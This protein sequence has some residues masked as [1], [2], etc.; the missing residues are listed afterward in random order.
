MHCG[1]RPHAPQPRSHTRAGAWLSLTS[2]GSDLRGLSQG[3][4]RSKRAAPRHALV[5]GGR[6]RQRKGA[7]AVQAGRGG[8]GD[9]VYI[10]VRQT[11]TSRTPEASHHRAV[12]YSARRESPE[13][14]RKFQQ[15][16]QLMQSVE[17]PQCRVCAQTRAGI[18]LAIY[19]GFSMRTSQVH[20]VRQLDTTDCT[21]RHA[22]ACFGTGSHHM[23]LWVS[24]SKQYAPTTRLRLRS[25]TGL[26][27]EF[28][29]LARA[30]K[31]QVQ[32]VGTVGTA[33][34]GSLYSVGEAPPGCCMGI[35]ADRPAGCILCMPY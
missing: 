17:G 30:G 13:P 10:Q 32:P 34:T 15:A 21:S 24:S 19:E 2:R 31:L 33:Q 7:G 5:S 1:A 16:R 20:A 6:R 12:P 23:Q 4:L 14:A 11:L 29:A 35:G 9:H 28:V 3:A 25:W 27:P 8:H 18:F 26:C 22:L